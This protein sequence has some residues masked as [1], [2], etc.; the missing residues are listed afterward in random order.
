MSQR[1]RVLFF[2]GGGGTALVMLVDDTTA[3]AGNL[4]TAKARTNALI[5]ATPSAEVLCYATYVVVT[6]TDTLAPLDLVV[7]LYVDGPVPVAER[8]ITVPATSG[9][10]TLRYEVSWHHT[11]A[12]DGLGRVTIAARG[13]MLQVEIETEGAIPAGRIALD[14][15]E[16]DV[17][18]VLESFAN[19]AT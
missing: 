7:R 12:R 3:D 8:T 2:G 11:V 5:P 1:P 9:Q 15:I 18:I 14:G 17:E 10:R 13:F 6:A 16:C 4:Y 19:V